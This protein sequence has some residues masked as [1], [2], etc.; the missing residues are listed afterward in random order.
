[1]SYRK[2]RVLLSHRRAGIGDK[3]CSA[4]SCWLWAKN[5]NSDIAVLWFFSA[6]TSFNKNIFY[7]F[8]D[9]PSH[10]EGVKLI[11]Y[12]AVINVLL[13]FMIAIFAFKDFMLH[14]YAI[15]QK[16]CDRVGYPW[17][18]Y[19]RIVKLSKNIFFTDAYFSDSAIDKKDLKPFYDCLKLNGRLH[20][21]Y[22]S[23]LAK[24]FTNK[25]LIGLHVRSYYKEKANVSTES[26]CSYV[27]NLRKTLLMS[28]T[29]K[30][31]VFLATDSYAF[32]QA[33]SKK[34]GDNLLIFN[35]LL[36]EH[37]HEVHRKKQKGSDFTDQSLLEM[38]LLAKCN[39]LIR[40]PYSQFSLYPSFYVDKVYDIP[41]PH[42]ENPHG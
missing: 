9:V 2:R 19:K 26:I 18:N 11:R 38:F 14:R 13:I 37:E 23:F 7:H 30:V 42:L 39:V 33:I 28:T 32:Q 12:G 29:K 21:L 22:E 3:L 25:F 10:I 17:Y 34:L 24:E 31:V 15:L 36:V 6:Y 41:L 20:Q 8:F 4:A 5:N 35:P 27:L 16:I 40:T 1:M